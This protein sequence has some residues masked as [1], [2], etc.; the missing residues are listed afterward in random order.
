[1]K[2]ITKYRDDNNLDACIDSMQNCPCRV[3]YKKFPLCNFPSMYALGLIAKD[4]EADRLVNKI[5]KFRRNEVLQWQF[6]ARFGIKE[7]KESL[8]NR[9][10]GDKV[11]CTRERSDVILIEKDVPPNGWIKYR[12]VKGEEKVQHPI[13]F[14]TI[15]KGNKCAKLRIEGKDFRSKAE[16]IEL[17]AREL[18]FRVEVAEFKDGYL[19][20]IYG[21]SQDEVD[22]FVSLYCKNGFNVY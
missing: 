1:M 3:Y 15:S 10:V 18:G 11:Y 17:K 7:F 13:Y 6:T 12:T 8:S 9:V 19:F 20:K 2:D 4:G 14:R 5:C 21:D 22:D 16:I